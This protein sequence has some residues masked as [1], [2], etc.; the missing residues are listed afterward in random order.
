M[1]L[2]H[3]ARSPRV[4]LMYLVLCLLFT[5]AYVLARCDIRPPPRALPTPEP[6]ELLIATQNLWRLVD[7]RTDASADK[8]VTKEELARRI[9]DIAFHVR[10]ILGSPHVL[11][12]QEVENMPV[13]ELLAE[14]IVGQGGPHY[15]AFLLDGLDP[16][17]IDVALLVRDP[18]KVDAVNDLF[19]EAR[20]NR[21]PLFSR[22]PLHVKIAEPVVLELVVVHLRSGRGLED[23][24]RGKNVREKRR[25]QALMLREWVQ[26]RAAR[27]I[28]VTIIGDLNSA[29]SEEPYG[30]PHAILVHGEVGEAWDFL[31]EQERFSY[32]WRCKPQA[33]DNIVISPA[34]RERVTRGAVSRGNA[35]HQYR[36]YQGTAERLVSD[37]D[38]VALYLSTAVEEEPVS[39]PGKTT[40]QNVQGPEGPC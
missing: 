29:E 39:C 11:A 35:G 31:P 30:E 7:T 37:H 27:E 17:G 10:E 2:S 36:L 15:R 4:V 19:R 28:P 13:L 22:P 14:R 1:T 18:V 20:F 26:A 21:Y 3:A 23:K 24:R 8:P 5:P 25:R 6:H 33:I 16:S 9:D 32:V 34:L 12:L 38:A 40:A